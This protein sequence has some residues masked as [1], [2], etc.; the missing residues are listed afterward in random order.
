LTYR[1]LSL[2]GGGHGGVIQAMALADLYP[3]LAGKGILGEFDLVVAAGGGALVL[4]ALMA[5][6]SPAQIL[7]ALHPPSAA[8]PRQPRPGPLGRFLSR[9]GRGARPRPSGEGDVIATLM[10]EAATTALDQWVLDG[11]SEL[12]VGVMFVTLDPDRGGARFLRGYAMEATGEPADP[13]S[14]IGAV[15]AAQ[16]PSVR[17]GAAPDGAAAGVDNPV[18]AGVID[19]LAM[20]A[21]PEDIEVLS[22]GAGQVRL[23]PPNL[24]VQG[25]ATPAA[26]VRDPPPEGKGREARTPREGTREG[27]AD[28]AS[29]AAHIVLAGDPG[30]MGRVVRM[31][32]LAQPTPSGPGGW[33]YPKGLPAALFDALASLDRNAPGPLGADLAR[34][35]A[36]AWIRQ[37][38]PNQPIRAGADL[39][40]ALG[41]KTYIAAK[42]RW[43]NL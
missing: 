21:M 38:A 33:D 32:P 25:G 35:W 29:W 42:R 11:P 3:G 1:I 23:V 16:P 40:W 41:D 20:G 7:D 18:M 22:I 17:E 6:R 4:G 2:D 5:D 14:I 37:G 28:W 8:A 34:Q 26:L 10:G 13:V 43:R 12:P 39:S 15:R 31:N 30:E 9:F 24:V 19:A 27:P 36:E